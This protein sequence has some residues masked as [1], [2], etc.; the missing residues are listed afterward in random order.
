MEK[1]INKLSVVG[2]TCVKNRVFSLRNVSVIKKDEGPYKRI[3]KRVSSKDPEV[4]N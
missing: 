1:I 3:S 4:R 2:Y